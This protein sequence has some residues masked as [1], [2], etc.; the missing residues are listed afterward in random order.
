MSNIKNVSELTQN[1]TEY[2]NFC[3]N[4]IEQFRANNKYDKYDSNINELLIICDNIIKNKPV[5]VDKD[6]EQ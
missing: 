2:L 5:Y 4:L 3:F 6:F 1:E